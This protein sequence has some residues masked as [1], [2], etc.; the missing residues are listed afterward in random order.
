MFHNTATP[1][2]QDTPTSQPN[3]PLP[4]R[5]INVAIRESL[6]KPLK[7]HAVKTDREV[8]DIVELALKRYLESI[9]EL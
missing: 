1:V 5:R 4:E 8:R 9:G 2:S 6:Y 7:L 3:E